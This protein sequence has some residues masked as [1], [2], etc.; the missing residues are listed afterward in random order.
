MPVMP[1]H[2]FPYP[3]AGGSTR[4]RATVEEVDKAIK[5]FFKKMNEIEE[6]FPQLI[7]KKKSSKSIFNW[8]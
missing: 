7:K 2:L 6:T 8:K 4:N 5:P 1:P 3:R